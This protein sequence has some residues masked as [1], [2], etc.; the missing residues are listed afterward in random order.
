MFLDLP[1]CPS[2][3]FWF[4]LLLLRLLLFLDLVGFLQSDLTEPLGER[5]ASGPGR[6]SNGQSHH[7]L[8]HELGQLHAAKLS[9]QLTGQL[10]EEKMD[11]ELRSS[12]RGCD[13]ARQLKRTHS[14]HLHE[15]LLLLLLRLTLPVLVDLVA[16]GRQEAVVVVEEDR[17]AEL[18]LED[19]RRRRT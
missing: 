19:D 8:S 16:A 17:T 14:K 1:R 4:L 15:Q 10:E 13:A 12:G 2:G 6:V 5:H 11:S 7:V 3:V 9:L 18:L